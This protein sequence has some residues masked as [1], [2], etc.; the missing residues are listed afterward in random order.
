MKGTLPFF[1]F[2][3]LLQIIVGNTPGN[4]KPSERDPSLLSLNGFIIM[5]GCSVTFPNFWCK[6]I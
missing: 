6:K 5:I 3:A 4:C 1:L 2:R